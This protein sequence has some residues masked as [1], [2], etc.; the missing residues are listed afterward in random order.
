MV[1]ADFCDDHFDRLKDG[2]YWRRLAELATTCV[3]GSQEMAERVRYYAR[4]P[5]HVVA[6]PI[7]SPGSEPAVYRAVGALTGLLRGLLP[8]G[9]KAS[10]LKLVVRTSQ[11]FRHFDA[12]GGRHALGG[13]A[14]SHAAVGGDA[15]TS[16]KFRRG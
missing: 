1:I 3:A 9:A 2:A 16:P 11:Q 15:A 10:P 4:A 7:G 8:G 5:V 14:R 13:V 12:M 6:D